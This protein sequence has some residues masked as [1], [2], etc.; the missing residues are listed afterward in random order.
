ML[1]AGDTYTAGDTGGE[2]EITPNGT[3]G[4]HT[5]TIAEMPSHTHV[6]NS[7]SHQISIPFGTSGGYGLIDSGTASSSGNVHWTDSATA[8]N[9]NTGG[10]GSHNHSLT[11]NKHTNL[12]P[13]KVVYAWERTA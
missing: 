1:T 13:Y 12:P 10:G 5:L 3:V 4:G 6:Q 2:A 8:T 9:Q 7:H 11:L